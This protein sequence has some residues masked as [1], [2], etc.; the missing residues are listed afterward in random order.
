MAP[1]PTSPFQR[2]V[3]FTGR[4]ASMKREEAFAL[5]RERGGTPRRGLTKTTTILVVG[6][7]G[8]PLL[9]DG[10]PSK[11]LSLAKSYGVGVIL[12]A[13]LRADLASQ[14]GLD[15]LGLTPARHASALTG[16]PHSSGGQYPPPHRNIPG[17]E[18]GRWPALLAEMRGSA[19]L[20]GNVPRNRE[21]D[22]RL[23]A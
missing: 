16:W 8:W 21:T 3:A 1:E 4:L 9:P 19:T 5:V 14:F 17:N 13:K 15:I 7:L 10:Q 12:V 6:E 20:N 23:P 22:C 2:S 11:S 18:N